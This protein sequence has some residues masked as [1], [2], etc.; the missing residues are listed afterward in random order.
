MAKKLA[1][2]LLSSGLDSVVTATIASRSYDL[3][4]VHFNYGHRT[5]QVELERFK[6]LVQW[7]NP[8]KYFIIDLPFMKEIGGSSLVDSTLEVPLDVSQ[9][10]IPSTYVPFRNGIFLSIAAYIAEVMGAEAIFIGAN[11]VDFS[12]YPDCRGQFLSAI[13][14][15]IN[16]GTKPETQI[17]VVAPLLNCTKEEIVRI[18]VELGAPFELTWSCYVNNEIA[19]GRCESCRLRLEGFRK[20]GVKDPIPYEK[21]V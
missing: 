13:E 3:V 16:E 18:G 14:K 1:V 21:G 2:V 10:G 15:A 20:A 12:G 6:R 8:Y 19:C 11:Q 17:K 7:F 5:E 4:L 9:K